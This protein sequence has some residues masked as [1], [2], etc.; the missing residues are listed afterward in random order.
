MVTEKDII[1][2]FLKFRSDYCTH[3]ENLEYA[4]SLDC[5]LATMLE[6]EKRGIDYPES[7]KRIRADVM[8]EGEFWDACVAQALK[9][10]SPI[11]LELP[12]NQLLIQE[13]AVF[14]GISWLV[15]GFKEGL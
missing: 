13:K 15:K 4:N 12:S 2:E 8:E 9:E 11:N 14:M 1:N 3:Q 6:C 7:Y 5:A 10:Y